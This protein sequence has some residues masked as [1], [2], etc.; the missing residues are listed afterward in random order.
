MHIYKYEENCPY[1]VEK[2]KR[3]TAEDAVKEKY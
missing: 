2:N 3:D 1:K